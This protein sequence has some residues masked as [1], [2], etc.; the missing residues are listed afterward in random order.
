MEKL[1]EIEDYICNHANENCIRYM[2]IKLR[3]FR[4]FYLKLEKGVLP[5][6]YG[7]HVKSRMY[8]EELEF[9]PGKYEAIMKQ[10]E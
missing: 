1:Q 2:T 4:K 5:F 7:D 6:T 10:H 3:A 9:I 8:P